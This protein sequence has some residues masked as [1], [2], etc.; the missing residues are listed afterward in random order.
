MPHNK[1][2]RHDVKSLEGPAQKCKH[3]FMKVTYMSKKD[4]LMTLNQRMECIKCGKVGK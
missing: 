2:A 4:G 3:I 1:T